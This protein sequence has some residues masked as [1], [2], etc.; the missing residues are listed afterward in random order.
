MRNAIALIATIGAT[1]LTVV[2]VQAAEIRLAIAPKITVPPNWPVY[3]EDVANFYGT[4]I[5][6]LTS[7]FLRAKAEA[8]IQKHLPASLRVEATRVPN[9]SI[10]SVTA[11]SGDEALASSFLSAV[12]DQF[13]EFKRE[14][15]S[16]HYRD[17][18]NAIDSALTYVPAEYARKLEDY[19]Q[20]LVVASMLD[21]K[22][23][24]EKIDY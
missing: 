4:N 7:A 22:P 16:K 17:A 10:I 13:L 24:F 3:S 12:I 21:N 2:T 9:T 11:S 19:K 14:Q 8:Q 23:D 1:A 20:Q 18:I 5:A 6:L 15:K